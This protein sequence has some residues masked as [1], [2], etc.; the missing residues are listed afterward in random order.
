MRFVLLALDNQWKKYAS[1]GQSWN[2]LGHMMM[3]TV[4]KEEFPGA[5]VVAWD[6]LTKGAPDMET[7]IQ[8]GD[9]VF[10]SILVTGSELSIQYARKAR[11]RGARYVFA[12]DH[13]G[14]LAHRL[15]IRERWGGQSLFD[16]I[17]I[18]S[19]LNVVR[20][21]VRA[22]REDRAPSGPGVVTYEGQPAEMPQD[23]DFFCAPDFSVVDNWDQIIGNY[24]ET[25]GWM[26]ERFSAIRP[27]Q[28]RNA[29]IMTGARGCT[30]GK[31]K[32]CAFCGINEVELVRN[33]GSDHVLQLFTLYRENGINTF[34]A[35]ADS[36]FEN[37]AALKMLLALPSELRPTNLIL[38]GRAAG[39]SRRPYLLDE[40]RKV[41]PP[42]GLLKI[43][44]GL[45]GLDP[46]KFGKGHGSDENVKT[47]QEIAKRKDIC[48]HASGIIGSPGQTR[49]EVSRSI[50]F[51]QWVT[52][53]L[54]D[55]QLHAFE[56][57]YLHLNHAFLDSQGKL[58]GAKLGRLLWDEGYAFELN[59]S[60]SPHRLTSE[61]WR[62][63][64]RPYADRVEFDSNLTELYYRYFTGISLEEA[65]E[66]IHR[67]EDILA[68]GRT[69]GGRAY[70]S[71]N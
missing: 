5:E 54:G 46:S 50:E 48:L 38:Y 65:S 25:H 56:W 32:R 7:L 59:A 19:D 60:C 70:G 21:F 35:V 2:R 6:G 66:A 62:T 31:S 16:A 33:S 39:I 3:S 67:I 41:I 14:A 43:N 30:I 58:Q 12:G 49:Q 17:A 27:A 22:A 61:E 37:A 69:R 63:K 29:T 47:V 36:M 52:S 26:H 8:E 23:P 45:E 64:I 10:F 44:C 18:S 51:A 28:I 40:W 13:Q 20:E 11:E 9:V 53:T 71:L 34:Y 68:T 4:I 24:V 42:D 1:H 55:E 57:D 15:F